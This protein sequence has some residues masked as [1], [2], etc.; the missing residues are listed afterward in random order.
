MAFKIIFMPQVFDDVQDAV[1]W[2][3]ERQKGVGKR[4]FSVVKIHFGLLKKDP[5]CIAVKYDDI[6]CMPVSKFPYNI[7]YKIKSDSKTIVIFAVY[8]T[9]RNPEIWK[10]RT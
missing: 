3:N 9:S 10:E 2:Y 6:R 1:N 8:H 4:F 7:H 5:F